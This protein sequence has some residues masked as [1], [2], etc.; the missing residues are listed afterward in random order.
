M[1]SSAVAV[2]LKDEKLRQLAQLIRNHEVN[3]LYHITFQNLGDQL[4]YLRMSNNNMAS[5]GTLLDHCNAI[6]IRYKDDGVRG[7]IADQIL[8]YA[9]HCLSNALQIIRNYTLR[10]SYLDKMMDHHLQLFQALEELDTSSRYAVVD[11]TE[12]IQEYDRLVI[13]YMRLALNSYASAE[14][15]RYLRNVGIGFNELVRSYQSK[16]GYTGRFEDLE[17]EQKI[18]VY[19]AIIEASGRLSV[20]LGEQ[21]KGDIVTASS[22]TYRVKKSNHGSA[23]MFLIDVGHI[24]WDVYSSDQPIT[25]ATREAL[26][27]AAKTGGATLG[28]LVGAAIATQLTGVTATTLFVTAVGL[29]GGF[30][31]GFILGTVAGLL[32]DKIF[33]SGGEAVL[34]TDGFILYVATMPDGHDLAKQIANI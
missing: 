6:V 14:F 7:P 31:G 17:I 22:I 12:S 26:V 15:S 2:L 9:E 30:I 32:F 18:E 29:A 8:G 13:S 20:L 34:P 1:A 10:R 4:E 27:L 16:L 24:I 11:F 3:N 19:A 28:N 23:A 33:G 21:G 5:V 25:T